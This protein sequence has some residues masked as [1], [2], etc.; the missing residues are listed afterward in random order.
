M[1]KR[2][3]PSQ[4]EFLVHQAAMLER[5]GRVHEAIDAMVSAT[6]AAPARADLAHRAGV[7]MIRGR[8]YRDAVA[9]LT[10][11]SALA[12]KDA[13]IH[14]D[15]GTALFRDGEFARAAERFERANALDPKNAVHL[16]SLAFARERMRDRAGAM[17]AAESALALDP[18][19]GSAMVVVA[20]ELVRS[21]RAE[22]AIAMAGRALATPL[23]G[24]ME[25]RAHHVQGRA[26]ERL[27]RHDEAFAAH[28]R[29]NEAVRVRAGGQAALEKPIERLMRDVRREG[30]AEVFQRWAAEAPSNTPDPVFLCGFPRSGT[31]VVEQ[32]IG[33]LPGVATN[34]EQAHAGLVLREMQRARPGMLDGDLVE[35][36]DRLTAQ[37]VERHR[38][39]FWAQIV[40][41]MPGRG[42]G[43]VAIDKQ[44][45][46]LMD[47]VLV[48][49]LFPRAR[50]IVMVRDP[51]DV[52]LSALFQNFDPNP[53]MARF[54]T[55]ETTGAFYAEV[56]SF[57]LEMRGIVTMPWLEVEYGALVRDLAGQSRR[58]AGFL[59]VEWTA[60]VARFHEAAGGRAVTSASYNAVTEAIN[61]RSVGRWRK[62]AAHLG[63]VIEA[64]RPIVKAYGYEES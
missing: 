22:E 5:A 57:W 46:R 8:R 24:R 3:D 43:V 53:A 10:R 17:A 12:P 49:R 28:M 64:V 32:I 39:M 16:V 35:A 4:I 60:D 9:M 31:T 40:E 56:M 15:L 11:A 7:L 26:L 27:G 61:D 41:R 29:C 14:H 34:D 19:N 37:E 44:P 55:V 20:D 6:G 21:G 50:M 18:S 54:L 36:F 51:R 23:P 59:G 48:Q 30:L 33:M 45:L 52:C 2:A 38:A 1:A 62:Y 25:A 47:L 63:P 42:A 13:V 58:I